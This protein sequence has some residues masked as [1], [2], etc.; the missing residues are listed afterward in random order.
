VK[1]KNDVL[2]FQRPNSWTKS[3]KKPGKVSS[4]LFTVTSTPHL[5]IL[6]FFKLAQPFTVFAVQLLYTVKEKGGN[7]DRKPYPLPYD[8]RKPYR[9]LK[10]ENFQDYAQKPQRNCTFMNSASGQQVVRR[11]L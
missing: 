6:F 2:L 11:Y 4:L 10:S 5:E 1:R 8:L 9:N 3:R 7:P